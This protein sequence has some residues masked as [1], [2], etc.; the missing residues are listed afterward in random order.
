MCVS[1]EHNITFYSVYIPIIQ[2][3]MSIRPMHYVDLNVRDG[4]RTVV[5]RPIFFYVI[6][7]KRTS[8][9]DDIFY[10]RFYNNR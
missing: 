2:Q 5:G 10:H 7:Y 1:C 4:E 6:I 8:M 9:F 3:V